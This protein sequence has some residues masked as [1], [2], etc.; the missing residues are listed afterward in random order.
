M[1]YTF[2]PWELRP[3]KPDFAVVLQEARKWR[4]RAGLIIQSETN[5][6]K[7]HEGAGVIVRI[8]FGPIA[9]A[10]GLGVG[11][12]IMYRTYLR[13][14]TRLD[15]KD[16]DVNGEPREYFLLSLDDVLAVLEPEVE[17]GLLSEIPHKEL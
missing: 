16:L 11:T 14:I 7:L 17:V 3:T 15:S 6:E 10:E 4:T 12:R 13:H 9:K 5:F 2:Q 1:S 8:K